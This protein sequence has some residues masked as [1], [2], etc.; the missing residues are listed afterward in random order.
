M[1]QVSAL[2]SQR[3]RRLLAQASFNT[4]WTTQGRRLRLPQRDG[5]RLAESFSNRD[6]VL[7]PT[8]TNYLWPIY[9]LKIRSILDPFSSRD[10]INVRRSP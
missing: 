10:R 9:G 8:R 4:L 1:K 6:I 2:L 5:R 3:L 7:V